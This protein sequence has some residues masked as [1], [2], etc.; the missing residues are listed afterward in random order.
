MNT[1]T[2]LNPSPVMLDLSEAINQLRTTSENDACCSFCGRRRSI[3]RILVPGKNSTY[4]C[5]QCIE[6]AH[7]LVSQH[8]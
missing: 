7:Q 6:H 5:N 2:V 8:A 1:D 3:V 4:I